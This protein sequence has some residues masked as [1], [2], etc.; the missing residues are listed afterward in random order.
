MSPRPQRSDNRRN[1]QLLA[2][3]WWAWLLLAG[4]IFFLLQSIASMNLSG[5]AAGAVIALS[6]LKGFA[7][8]LQYLAPAPFVLMAV[9]SAARSRPELPSWQRYQYA[10]AP[11]PMFSPLHEQAKPDV[12]KALTL[13]LLRQIDWKNFEEV[14]AA[15][16]RLMGFI[17]KTQSHGPDG[18]IDITLAM[19]DAPDQVVG[20]VQCKQWSSQV[21][22]KQVRELLGV[23]TDAKVSEGMFITTSTFNV[24]AQV[25]G[26]TNRIDLIDGER[27]M[28]LIQ[29]HPP[30]AQARLLN[31]ATQGDYLTPTCAACGVKM[32]RR[33]G[34]QGSAFWGC[35]NYPRCKLTIDR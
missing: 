18:G 14:C 30:E 21:G 1:S 2:V 33:N 19:P 28:H 5:K 29:K 27:L 8:V 9:I 7:S 10:E 32:V 15:Y 26:E 13:D 20:L 22:P 16:L 6:A 12:S 31:I 34:R 35:T 3:P 11:E 17:A 4:F 24:E 23:M 25:F